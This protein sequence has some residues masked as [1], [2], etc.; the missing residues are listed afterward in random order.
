MLKKYILILLISFFCSLHSFSQKSKISFKDSLDHRID[1]SDWIITAKGFIPIVALISEPA[2]GGFGGALVPVFIK[3]NSPYID[4]INGQVVKTK[5]KPNMYAAGAAYT[6]NETWLIMAGA[7]GT[8]KKIRTNYRL[9]GGYTSINMEFYKKIL[10]DEELKFEFNIQSIPIM[11]QFTK[12]LF[13]SH[14]STGINYTFMQNK[15]STPNTDFHNIKEIKSIISKAA[16]VVDYD[17]RDNFFTPNKGFR[18]NT[19]ISTSA[20]YI[21]SDYD[22]NSLSTSAFLYHPIS[23][24]LIAGFRAE[25]QQIWGKPP[26]YLNPFVNMRGIPMMRYQGKLTSLIETEWRWDFTKRHSVIA[27]G[28]LAKA[29][30]EEKT[31]M[32]SPLLYAAGTGWRYLIARKLNLRMGLDIAHGPEQWAYYVV[33]GTSWVR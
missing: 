6:A 21:G 25:Y 29:K 15:I 11:F 10:D 27:F 33:F 14:W 13:K 7:T 24:N 26:F 19:S 12:Q 8:I 30:T 3:P 2:L 4:T 18:S 31:F 17:N 22:F 1:L 9:F 32:E 16:L 28:G 23:P 5:V 20:N